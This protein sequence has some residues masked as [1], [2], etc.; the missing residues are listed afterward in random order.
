MSTDECSP[1][2][3]QFEIA[4]V[5]IG[6][7]WEE[8]GARHPTKYATAGNWRHPLFFDFI[9]QAVVPA[10]YREPNN[11]PTES[12]WLPCLELG[13]EGGFICFRAQPE[14]PSLMVSWL[15]P[16]RYRLS[17][18]SMESLAR[19]LVTCNFGEHRVLSCWVCAVLCCA[20]GGFRCVS[21]SVEQ[22][23]GGSAALCSSPRPFSHRGSSRIEVVLR[24][25]P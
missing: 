18:S 16:A 14:P 22:P 2:R 6:L 20:E 10:P 7:E 13:I 3:E 12:R 23:A 15:I 19:R 5:V 24:M 9:G 21:A 1:Y 25:V 11:D 8:L 17:I 4:D